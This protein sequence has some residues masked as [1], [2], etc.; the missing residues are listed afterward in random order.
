M[1]ILMTV[2]QPGGLVEEADRFR[3]LLHQKLRAAPGFI[4]H[5]DGPVDGGWQ[6][7]NAWESRAD[8]ERW[9]ETEVKPNLGGDQGNA[10]PKITELAN[11]VIR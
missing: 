10:I 2:V 3:A 4:F 6:V 5:V 7:I 9:F 8:F 11:V 1:A